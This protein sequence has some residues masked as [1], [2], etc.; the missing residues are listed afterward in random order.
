MRIFSNT[1]DCLKVANQG[2]I[3]P[4]FTALLTYYNINWYLAP[5]EH[6]SG[7]VIASGVVNVLSFLL[8]ILM[9][10]TRTNSII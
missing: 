8:N 2:R 4:A 1:I 5:L 10:S 7:S 3:L 6:I 9:A